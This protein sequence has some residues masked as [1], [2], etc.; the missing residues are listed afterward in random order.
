MTPI[1]MCRGLAWIRC[2]E[3]LLGLGGAI[4]VQRCAH[5]RDVRSRGSRR[6]GVPRLTAPAGPIA[7][8]P[9]GTPVGICT[10][11]SSES[12]PLSVFGLHRYTR[13]R[14]RGS[15]TRSCPASGSCAAGPAMMTSSP[16]SRAQWWRT[17]T[18]PDRALR[19]AET[20][21]TGGTPKAL[22]ACRP[23]L[24]RLP[25]RRR[26]MMMPTSAFT[27][28]LYINGPKASVSGTGCQSVRAPA[29]IEQLAADAGRA[30][31]P[32][33]VG[34]PSRVPRAPVSPASAAGRRGAP[35]CDD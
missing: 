9:T 4:S 24:E 35:G 31:V 2:G 6:R 26:T 15:L 8:V 25:V 22:R 7:S 34:A 33:R 5:F 28:A 10:I 11:E 13:H 3:H 27:E 29:R 1:L 17:R 20:T 12:R 14:Q 21:R 23:G 32:T 30:C 19:C 16:R 18:A